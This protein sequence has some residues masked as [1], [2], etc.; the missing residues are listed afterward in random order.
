M[1]DRIVI[2][3]TDDA[4]PIELN[5]AVEDDNGLYL[6]LTGYSVTNYQVFDYVISD[7]IEAFFRAVEGARVEY[8]RMTMDRE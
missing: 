2:H 3:P 8:A 7:D 6:A 4:E 1:T 5:I